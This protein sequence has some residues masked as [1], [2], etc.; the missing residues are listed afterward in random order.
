MI[1]HPCYVIGIRR[2]R[3]VRGM[4][5]ITV[6]IRQLVIT[7]GVARL[8]SCCHV[9]SG[10][11]KFR[12]T[13]IERRRLPHDRRVARL[14]CMTEIRRHV[15]RIRRLCE[16][17]RVTRIAVS[18]HKLVVTVDMARLTR[19]RHM[20]PCQYEPGRTMVER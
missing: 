19:R 8:T 7:V 15:V 13:V 11:G 5:R 16:I 14:T 9:R 10:Q 20:R 12:G 6:R 4:A 17:C 2:S 1:Q 3:V 18:I